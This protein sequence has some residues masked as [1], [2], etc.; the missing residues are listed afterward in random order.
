MVRL[1]QSFART[2]KEDMC[3][4]DFR[5]NIYGCQNEKL[6]YISIST[7]IPIYIIISTLALTNLYYLIKV[8][9]QDLFLP[10]LRERGLLRPRPLHTFHVLV[11]L[12][13]LSQTIH[14]SLLLSESYANITLAEL[15]HSFPYALLGSFAAILAISFVYSTPSIEI[16]DN[17]DLNSLPNK[18][19]L[20]VIG[21][22][23]AV[24]PFWTWF[25]LSILT[26]IHADLDDTTFASKLFTAQY[27]AW[28]IWCC[29]YLFSLCFIWRRL[30]LVIK[31]QIKELKNR[32]RN[33]SDNELERLERGRRNIC[34]PM[35]CIISGIMI[36]GVTFGFI[37][38]YYRETIIFKFKF[39]I[40]Y[41]IVWYCA[42]PTIELLAE[43][44]LLYNT[45]SLHKNYMCQSTLPS[46]RSAES[47]LT[48]KDSNNDNV[49]SLDQQPSL[50]LD[51]QKS[52]MPLV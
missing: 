28:A 37:S 18:K 8:K 12:N 24:Q 35:S 30:D 34:F 26:G 17:I 25:P 42:Y 22:T 40:I 31:Y 27:S 21:F 15:G 45:I 36:Q 43:C 48:I 33:G 19:L 14:N 51:R 46:H 23:L 9:R 16:E 44:V 50:Q 7:L 20:D 1:N 11:I 4:C 13:T 10:K 49:T 39:G 38:F 32:L 47:D 2:C 6:F 5:I 41:F 52:D 3:F 29:L